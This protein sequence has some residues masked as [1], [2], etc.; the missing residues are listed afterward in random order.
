M[1][2]LLNIKNH[3]EAVRYYN[4]YQLISNYMHGD[5][6]GDTT[7]ELFFNNNEEDVRKM[8]LFLAAYEYITEHEDFDYLEDKA[9]TFFK[10]LGL[11]DEEAEEFGAE[12]GDN[13]WEG[14]ITNEGNGAAFVGIDMFYWNDAG[15]QFEV[16]YT[17]TK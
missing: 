9:S 5:A 7:I 12:F 6:D 10:S 14:D 17:V 1:E 2:V 13:F 8:K 11:D 16:E 3:V 15:A 4:Q